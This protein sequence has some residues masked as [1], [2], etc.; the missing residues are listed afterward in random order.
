MRRIVVGTRNPGKVREIRALLRGLPVELVGLEAFPDAPHVDEDGDTFQANAIQKAT[1]LAD[2]LGEWVMAEDSGLEVDAL[3]GRPGVRSAR[4]AGPQQDADANNRKLLEEL[5]GVPEERRGA[6]Y[7]SVFALARP[8]RLLV[9]V[10]G[11]CDGRIALRPRGSHGFGY[12]PLFVWP[13]LGKTFA[14][15]EPDVKNRLSHRGRALEALR[16]R[17]VGLLASEA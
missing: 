4:F 1:V 11:R 7:R 6:S 9:A 5:D 17:L 13:D 10:D 2:A 15:L 3:G 16:H 14:E 12:D 8:G